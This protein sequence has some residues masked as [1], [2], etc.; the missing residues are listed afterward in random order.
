MHEGKTF[1]ILCVLC[2][3][4]FGFGAE[5]SIPI[6]GLLYSYECLCFLSLT[7]SPFGDES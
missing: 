1:V 7:R 3:Y 4:S 6:P 2:G 5:Y